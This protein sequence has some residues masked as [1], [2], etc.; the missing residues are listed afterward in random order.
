MR[1]PFGHAHLPGEQW[2]HRGRRCPAR[3]Q[4]EGFLVEAMRWLGERD[5]GRRKRRSRRRPRVLVVDDNADMRDYIASLLR[6][7]TRVET[8]TDGVEALDAR[9]PTRPTSC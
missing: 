8:A 1:V 5:G 9:G 7:A 2:R 3:Q 6:A 4:A